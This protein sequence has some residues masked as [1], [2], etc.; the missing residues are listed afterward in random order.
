M[1]KKPVCF[2]PGLSKVLVAVGPLFLVACGGGGTPAAEA[3]SP[4][5]LD[6]AIDFVARAGDQQIRCAEPITGLGIGG[7]TADLRDL[8]F[9][10]SDVALLDEDEQPVPVTLEVNEWQTDRVTLIDLEDGTGA[11]E[12]G[13]T[14]T[15]FQITG[16]VPAGIY[17]GV[18]MTIGV[19]SS[20]NHSDYAVATAPLDIQ[21]M[22]WSWQSGRKFMKIEVDPV[23]GVER[24]APAAPGRSFYVHLGSTGCTGNPVTGETVSCARSGRMNFQFQEFDMGRQQIAVDLAGLFQSSNLSVDYGGAAGCMSGETD[25]ECGPIFDALKLDLGSGESIGAGR[26]QRIFRVEPK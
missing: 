5:P 25:P 26:G 6:V 15:N 23:G 20:D 3:E 7:V 8:R 18:R 16:K 13:S 12:G 10:V 19:P 24:P 9:Y 1:F 21:A 14:A 2:R 22:A 11:C 4:A 17:K